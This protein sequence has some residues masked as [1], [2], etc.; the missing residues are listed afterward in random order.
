M[1]SC[2]EIASSG[3]EIAS[4][5]EGRPKSPAPVDMY[6]HACMCTHAA[7]IAAAI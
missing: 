1:S 2:E 4:S 5:G 3:E 6:V 7:R